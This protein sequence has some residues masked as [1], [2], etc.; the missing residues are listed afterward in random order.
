MLF[1]FFSSRRRH[2]RFDCDWSSDVC[3]SDLSARGVIV[4]KVIEAG[5]T[6][7]TP[8]VME[9]ITSSSQLAQLPSTAY[10]I[11]RRLAC[12]SIHEGTSAAS[13]CTWACGGTAVPPRL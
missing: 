12:A 13:H 1:F 5:P 2:T 11:Q 8:P 3:S 7:E 4:W 6:D 10:S 9:R